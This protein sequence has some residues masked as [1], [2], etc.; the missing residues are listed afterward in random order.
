MTVV[1]NLIS[2]LMKAKRGTLGL[3]FFLLELGAGCLA[4]HDALMM[5]PYISCSLKTCSINTHVSAVLLLAENALVF[6]F[7]FFCFPKCFWSPLSH[8]G[9]QYLFKKEDL[10]VFFTQCGTQKAHSA[11]VYL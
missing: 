7:F 8:V 10:W 9:I 5:P 4:G 6:C 11:F 3:H 2:L 1:H